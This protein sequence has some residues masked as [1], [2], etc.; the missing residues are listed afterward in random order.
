MA[1]ETLLLALFLM[2]GICTFVLVKLVKL[3]P[4]MRRWRWRRF[5]SRS[6]LRAASAFANAPVSVSI[7]TFFGITLGEIVPELSYVSIRQHT[8]VIRQHT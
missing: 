5:S 6:F 1:L 8:S 4:R 3:V 7:C 2:S